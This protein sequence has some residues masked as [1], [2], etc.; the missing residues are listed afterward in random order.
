M[1]DSVERVFVFTVH[2]LSTLLE[3]KEV[4][5]FSVVSS[6]RRH[7]H[8]SDPQVELVYSVLSA[9]IAEERYFNNGNS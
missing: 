2:D 6:L 1:N 3:S 8:K 7:L 5:L 9:N 4:D